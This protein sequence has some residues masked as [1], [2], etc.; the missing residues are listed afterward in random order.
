MEN[1][2]TDFSFTDFSFDIH[3]M[4]LSNIHDMEII[5]QLIPSNTRNNVHLE[6]YERSLPL[7]LPKL[8]IGRRDYKDKFG[9]DSN[10]YLLQLYI[11]R[12]FARFM[13]EREINEIDTHLQLFID[14]F[15]ATEETSLLLDEIVTAEDYNINMSS[16]GIF[17]ISYIQ[18]FPKYVMAQISFI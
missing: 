1:E 5:Y 7:I 2:V 6:I 4:D 17:G 16:F 3:D 14:N 8:L 18:N 11:F 13:L 15:G 12:R 9:D 10:I